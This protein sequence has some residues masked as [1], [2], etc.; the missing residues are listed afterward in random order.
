MRPYLG[1]NSMESYDRPNC[2]GCHKTAS[3]INANG[4]PQ[5]LDFMFWLKL[6][7]PESN[8][9]GLAVPAF[10]RAGEAV[11]IGVLIIVGFWTLRRRKA[12]E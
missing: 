11:F 7:V 2:T 6:E 1:N 5:N 8:K 3:H 4:V 9:L 10:G 12:I